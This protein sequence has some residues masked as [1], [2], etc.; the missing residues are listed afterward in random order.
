MPMQIRRTATPNA[1]PTGLAEGQLGV[2]MV[3]AQPRLWVGVPTGVDALGRRLVNRQAIVSA[4]AP[5]NPIAGDLWWDPDV[6]AMFLW[7]VDT[8]GAQWVE[9]STADFMGPQGP[10]GPS[11][12]TFPDAP[13]GGDTYLRQNG[14]WVQMTQSSTWLAV[15]VALTLNVEV[16]GPSLN[17]GNQGTWLV[18]SSACCAPTAANATLDVRLWD[19]V[20]TIASGQTVIQNGWAAIIALTGIIS[21]PVGPVKFSATN[22]TTGS[23]TSILASRSPFAR[24]TYLCAVRI[25]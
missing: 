7:H 16:D 25:G 9:V 11:G 19:G 1:P 17:V 23:G 18:N 13:I 10:P 5:T 15:N 20:T 12:G 24:D 3:G 22:R 4:A 2:E 21:N 14:N 8:T 6:G